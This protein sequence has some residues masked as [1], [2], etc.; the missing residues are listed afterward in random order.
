MTEIAFATGENVN[1]QSAVH[2]DLTLF[3]VFRSKLCSSAINV[4]NFVS[5]FLTTFFSASLICIIT[6]IHISRNFFLR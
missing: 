5:S 1:C 2:R 3:I 4:F 6:Y